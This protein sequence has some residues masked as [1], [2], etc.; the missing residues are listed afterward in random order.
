MITS[1][2]NP[3]IKAIRA[4]RQRK[5]RDAGGRALLE[6]IRLVGEALQLGAAV[7]RLIVAPE[8]LRSSF[9]H[10]LVA[11][12]AGSGIPVME[13][14]A[15]VFAT[16]A[17]K[18]G[19][20][21]LAAVIRQR[22]HALDAVT[23]RDGPGW[24]ALDGIADPG[25]LG[26]ILRTADAVGAGGVILVGPTADPYDPEA[27]RAAMGA[28][29]SLGLVRATPAELA[30]WKAGC[31]VPFVGTSDKATS[32]YRSV[33]YPTPLVLLMGSE[34]QGLSAELTAL[35]DLMVR[36]PMYGRSDSLNL[37]VA[38]GIMLYELVRGAA[39]QGPATR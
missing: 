34:R 10:G 23:L 16:L 26:T 9:A 36:I 32:D 37:A 18:E 5:E 17:Q 8:L 25:N 29:F 39:E 24:V 30:A 2:A 28:T 11:T 21:G 27:L 7:E 3:G 4:L 31:G 20:Q 6:G 14:T 35:C 22:W 19:P 38:T 1:T 15:N 12:A 33:A 13:V